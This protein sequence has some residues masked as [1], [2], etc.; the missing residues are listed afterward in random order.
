M[1]TQAEQR[2]HVSLFCRLRHDSTPVNEDHQANG[3][4]RLHLD[5]SSSLYIMSVPESIELLRH[6]S[7]TLSPVVYMSSVTDY[8]SRS[9]I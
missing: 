6:F 7:V 1:I 2:T 5:V 4:H 3:R 9:T 8:T